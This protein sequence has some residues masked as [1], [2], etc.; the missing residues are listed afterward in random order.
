MILYSVLALLATSAKVVT[1]GTGQFAIDISALLTARMDPIIDPGNDKDVGHVH[2]IFGA[3]NF[4]SQPNTH[5][6]MQAAKCTS[7]MV[8]ADKSNYW[9][10][11]LFWKNP[12]NEYE[13][14]Y[15]Q[16]ARAYYV[17]GDS[18]KTEP[19]PDGL[20]MISGSAINRGRSEKSMGISFVTAESDI[21][22][23]L[24]NN[25]N[26]ATGNTPSRQFAYH[27]RFPPCGTGELDSADHFSHMSWLHD[28]N[29]P[30]AW[31]GDRCPDSKATAHRRCEI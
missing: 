20:R 26:T 19:F 15:L 17:I 8:G 24:P 2:T 10:P 1:A 21:G 29:G 5:D 30:S 12:N 18:D 11:T 9:V 28:V 7:A 22:P 31:G 6:Q 4:R 3:S 14:A 16:G 25:T 23:Y 13:A 27:I